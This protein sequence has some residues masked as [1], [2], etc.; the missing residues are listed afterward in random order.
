MSLPDFFSGGASS[1]VEGIFSAHQA[2]RNRDFQRQMSNTAHQREVRDLRNA[3]LNPILS[4]MGGSG[5]STPLGAVADTP[6]LSAAVGVYQAGKR[7]KQELSNMKES[8]KNVAADTALK[9]KD[10][11]V[12]SKTLEQIDAMIENINAQTT[13]TN[14][15]AVPLA[16]DA[17][18][19]KTDF[20]HLLRGMQTGSS[21]V[22]PMLKNLFSAK[23]LFKA[24]P[25]QKLFNFNFT[26]PAK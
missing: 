22:A 18:L 3:G 11:D 1:I 15:Q 14:A 23:S 17:E 7:L 5:A 9:Y 21:T 24:K 6:N 8:E 4:A 2:K 12:K 26:T 25:G 19:F 10:Y 16:I 20:G 13:L